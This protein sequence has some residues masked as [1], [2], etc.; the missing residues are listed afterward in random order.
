[1]DMPTFIAATKRD[2]AALDIEEPGDTKFTSDGAEPQ[3]A[4]PPHLFS[5][6]S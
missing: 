2:W 3:R 5:L 6:F 4:A 1:M